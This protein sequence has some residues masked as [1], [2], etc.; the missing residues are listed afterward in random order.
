MTPSFGDMALRILDA[1]AEGFLGLDFVFPKLYVLNQVRVALGKPPLTEYDDLAW[2]SY[3]Q[4]A[5]QVGG[6]LGGIIEYYTKDVAQHPISILYVDYFE[7]TNV[8]DVAIELSTGRAVT[9]ASSKRSLS[10]TVSSTLLTPSV[11]LRPASNLRLPYTFLRQSVN[12]VL[13]GGGSGP[14]AIVL[15]STPD[16]TGN[17]YTDDQ[18][19]LT[20][21]SASNV[22]QTYTFSFDYL[23]E[24]PPV[25]ISTLF[26]AGKNTVSI[27]LSDSK[28]STMALT[29]VQPAL[30]GSYAYYV[31]GMNAP[32]ALLLQPGIPETS[33]SGKT[34]PFVYAQRRVY[35]GYSKGERLVL[36]STADGT[37]DILVDDE[38]LI[39]VVDRNNNKLSQTV[40]SDDTEDAPVDVTALFGEGINMVTITLTDTIPSAY[41]C[42]PIYLV[43]VPSDVMA[44][45]SS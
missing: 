45:R 3:K 13:W 27:T 2:T 30:Y 24:M 39:E 23:R 20:V 29:D 32:T 11:H 25:D 36:S 35:C 6:D 33:D 38:L 19:T 44:A 42:W 15:S 16:G 43:S 5:A 41:R 28:S 4:L 12:G 18:M 31:V 17:I 37:G 14:G 34:L 40:K 10:T 9:S 21:V 26:G 8:V 22:V 1:V 7:N